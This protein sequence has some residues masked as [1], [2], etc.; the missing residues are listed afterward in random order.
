MNGSVK[1]HRGRLDKATKDVFSKEVPP[2]ADHLFSVDEWGLSLLILREEVNLTGKPEVYLHIGVA[3]NDS[4]VFNSLA[5]RLEPGL[6]SKHLCN[7]IELVIQDLFP[8]DL[9]ILEGTVPDRGMVMHYFFN[10]TGHITHYNKADDSPG[11][12]DNPVFV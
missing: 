6:C 8:L 10:D 3:I 4:D 7:F 5:T 2:H 9:L 11:H 12:P 1:F